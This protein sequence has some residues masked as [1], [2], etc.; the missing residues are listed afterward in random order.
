MTTTAQAFDTFISIIALTDAQKADVSGKRAKTEEYL[1]AAF[2]ASSDVPLNRVVLIGS[3]DRGTMIRPPKDID[4]MAQF[5]DKDHAFEKYRYKSGDFL[6]R[7][8]TA[9]SANTQIAQIGARG[10]AVRLF[11]TAGP[12]VDIAPVFKWTGNGYA[13]PAGDGTWMTTDPEAQATWLAG[14]KSTVGASLRPLIRLIKRWND[15]HSRHF[16]SYHLEVAVASMFKT[17]GSNYREALQMFF[18]VA[19]SHLSVVD[20]AGHSGQLDDYLT[21]DKRQALVARLSS[22]SDRAKMALAAETAGNHEEAKRL[23]ALELGGDFPLG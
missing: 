20:P 12:Y 22:A 19:P 23:W 1:R 18:E 13:L 4:V 5:I 17:V 21:W 9:L 16:H 8:R 11:Y 15:C 14:R 6:Q 2:P 10:Q 3:A 7:L